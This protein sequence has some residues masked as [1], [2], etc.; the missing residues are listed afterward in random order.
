MADEPLG[1][2]SPVWLEKEVI[3]AII[4]KYDEALIENDR[5]P[6][7]LTVAAS[8]YYGTAWLNLTPLTAAQFF[9]RVRADQKLKEALVSGYRFGASSAELVAMVQDWKPEQ[10]EDT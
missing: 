2:D 7:W 5:A 9:D 8:A 3:R 10:L 4:V 6:A 1:A